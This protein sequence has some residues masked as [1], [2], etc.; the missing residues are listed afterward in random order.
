MFLFI[1]VFIIHFTILLDAMSASTLSTLNERLE[2]E[3]MNTGVMIE[4][5][6]HF[7]ETDQMLVLKNISGSP[8]TIEGVESDDRV[9][10]VK[11]WRKGE[12]KPGESFFVNVRHKR[13]PAN[14]GS[15][16]EIVLGIKID[17]SDDKQDNTFPVR[18]QRRVE[19]D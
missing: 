6:Q 8:F 16:T 4:N 3:G 7:Y 1:K 11:N 2:G 17:F 10:V 12:I 9:V 5:H 14:I 13:I 18:I 19:D 15:V